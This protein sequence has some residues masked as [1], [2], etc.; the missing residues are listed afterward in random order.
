MVESDKK[1]LFK[2]VR[3]YL[4][5]DN[6]DLM[7]KTSQAELALFQK[8]ELDMTSSYFVIGDKNLLNKF[9]A[10]YLTRC[11]KARPLYSQSS[12]YEYFENSVRVE[13]DEYGL[14]VSKDLLFLYMHEHPV[15]FGKTMD[16][17]A[18]NV[19]NRIADRNR[20]GLVTIILS[21]LNVPE[22]EKCNEFEIINL[23]RARD[24]HNI[25]HISTNNSSSK[26]N[27]TS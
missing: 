6:W 4:G 25:Q 19:I 21:E 9:R 5:P 14:N 22:F 18:A 24:S 23:N 16:F 10:F 7:K 13:K 12:L 8:F 27:Y 17:V 15:D 1:E 26:S 2:Y 20:K 11:L 3:L